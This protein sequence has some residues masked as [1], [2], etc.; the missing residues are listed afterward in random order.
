MKRQ[1]GP[2]TAFF[3][4]PAA[5]IVSKDGDKVNVL[6]VSWIGIVSETPP[7]VGISLRRDR[8]SL[9]LI[10]KTK[11]FTVNIPSAN[12]YRETDYCGLV[13][14]R[15]RDKLR[16]LNFTMLESRKISTPIIKECPYNME[17]VV[18]QEI[19][20]GEW[21]LILAEIVETHLDE[22]K[23]NPS[24]RANIEISKVVNPLVYCAEVREYWSL[25]E[26]LGN[27]FSSGKEI[28]Q[29]AGKK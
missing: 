21:V 19:L 22:D 11:E 8:Y 27:G 24:N 16:D 15:N 14:G 13:S 4:I 5:L 17:C 29:R 10:R 2:S 12:L 26:K 28:I 23:I 18:K 25:G 6:T 3:P 20:L 7:M 9:E 1:L